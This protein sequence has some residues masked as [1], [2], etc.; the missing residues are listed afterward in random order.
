MFEML[1][2][3]GIYLVYDRKSRSDITLENYK[4][5]DSL[6]QHEEFLKRR[7]NELG[8]HIKKW[9]KEVVSG[10][11]IQ[12]RPEIQKLLKE[13]ELGNIDGV[14]VVDIDRLARGDTT[15]QG[16]ISRT[17]KYTNTKIITLNKIYDPKNEEDEEFFEFNL[18][19][20]RKEYKM[21]N[22][23]QQRGRIASVM[24]GKF[25]GSVPPYGYNK[26]KIK[27]DKGFTLEPNQNEEPI[28]KMIFDKIKK[29]VGLNIICNYLNDLGIKPRKTDI[30]TPS[31]LI[32]MI[33]NPV[34]VGKIRWNLNKTIKCV[35]NGEIIKKRVRKKDDVILVEGL[36]EGIIDDETFYDVQK[37]IPNNPKLPINYDLKNSLAGIVRCGI[38]GRTMI[39]RPYSSSSNVREENNLN[40]DNLRLFLRKYKGSHSLNE[41][42]KHLKISKFI[43]DRWFSNKLNSFVV[44]P[45]DQYIK[46]KLF[47]SINDDSFDEDIRLYHSRTKKPHK[48]TLMC[49]KPHCKT[50]ASDLRLVE[51]KI[52]ELTK[53]HFRDKE[54]LLKNYTPKMDSINQNEVDNLEKEISSL[55]N[56]L[57]KAY[58]LVEKGIYS[59]EEFVDRTKKLKSKIEKSRKRLDKINSKT[60]IDDIKP[61]MAI[62]K[63]VIEKYDNIDSVYD[64]NELLK[65]IIDYVEYSK[66]KRGKDNF[67]LNIHFKF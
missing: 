36:H 33:S 15:D 45:F 46:L 35:R 64:K 41:I 7:I 38:C 47:L 48:D 3:N 6:K 58:D 59:S 62:A 16:I 57:D 29:R 51:N 44:P 42:A 11:N 17:F 67:T 39:R 5:I 1:D 63:K 53:M 23:R 49:P 24:A 40:K 27:G 32:Y 21:I 30:W 50:V 10:D 55:E 31:T 34:Y 4:K 14:L 22:K 20:A 54:L 18:F 2:K 65:S 26:V 43:V 66:F 28:A 25:C 37:I 52:I 9:Y 12:D 60:N 8:I 13:V 61:M 56:Q 19:F